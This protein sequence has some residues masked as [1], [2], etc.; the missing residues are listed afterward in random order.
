M[1]LNKC[2]HDDAVIALCDAYCFDK[3]QVL[4]ADHK[5]GTVDQGYN[6]G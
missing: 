6:Q 4:F 1:V 5:F 2:M 3:W